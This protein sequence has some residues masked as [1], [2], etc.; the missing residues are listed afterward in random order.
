M[1]NRALAPNT[2]APDAAA[3][4]PVVECPGL[5]WEGGDRSAVRERP[6]AEEP[7]VGV[8]RVGRS[9]VYSQQGRL[10]RG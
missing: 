2:P 6:V 4:D 10:V 3:P 5:R 7:L 9:N 8:A 1:S